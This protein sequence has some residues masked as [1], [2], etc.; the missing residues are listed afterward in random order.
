MR[1]RPFLAGMCIALAV[2][3][4]SDGTLTAS[5]YAAEVEQLVVAM[6]ARFGSIDSAWEAQ[7]PS[8]AGAAEYWDQWLV[9][10]ADFLESVEDLNHPKRSPTSTS[11]PSMSLARSQMRTTL[12]Q[13]G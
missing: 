6:E 5:E 8:V 3:G 4:C 7:I 1:I 12:L 2:A 11:Q 9:I 13:P 10:R